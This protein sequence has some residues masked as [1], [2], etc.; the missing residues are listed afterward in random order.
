VL[1]EA[2]NRGRGL[3]PLMRS[4]GRTADPN[5]RARHRSI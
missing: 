5:I 1:N 4:S 2:E 3:M